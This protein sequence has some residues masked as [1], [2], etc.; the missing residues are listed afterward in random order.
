MAIPVQVPD[1]RC[2]II[3]AADHNTEGLTHLNTGNKVL[4]SVKA[5]SRAED[6]Y[7][8]FL[9]KEVALNELQY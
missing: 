1:D 8:R 3:A 9:E 2:I 6:F 7:T 4:V 5:N